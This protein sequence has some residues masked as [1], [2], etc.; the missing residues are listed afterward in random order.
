MRQTSQKRYKYVG[1]ECDN[2]TGLYYYGARYYAAWLCRF[3]SVDPLADDY[4]F[5]NPYAYAAN[6]PIKFIDVNGEGPEDSVKIKFNKGIDDSVLSKHSLRVIRK[7][8]YEA[9]LKE[10][11]VTSTFRSENKQIE[12]MYTNIVKNGVE[13]QKDTYN[14]KGDAIIDVYVEKSKNKSNTPEAIM[15]SMLEKANELGFLSKHS[16]QDYS[17]HN[18]ID[19]SYKYLSD[20]QYDN[21]RVAANDCE[22]ISFVRGKEEG[23]AALHIE[24]PVLSSIVEL[25]Q[26]QGGQYVE[27]YKKGELQYE[28]LTYMLDEL[29]DFII[30]INEI[31]NG[32]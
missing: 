24:I 12:T 10:I 8:A 20:E 26:Q 14:T 27:Q 2:E 30:Y 19:I 9:G 4:K 11:V 25:L 31:E 6:N 29:D 5:Q 7:I 28:K 13:D 22:Y 21:L 15:K 1:K 32:K 23:D 18:A 3:V 17:K 16:S